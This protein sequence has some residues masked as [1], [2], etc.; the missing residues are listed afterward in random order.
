M[1][2]LRIKLPTGELIGWTPVVVEQSW[3]VIFD[4]DGN[5]ICP[6]GPN[7]YDNLLQAFKLPDQRPKDEDEAPRG[8]VRVRSVGAN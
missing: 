4:A 8:R 2:R 1:D 3:A 6:G 5:Y 7:Y